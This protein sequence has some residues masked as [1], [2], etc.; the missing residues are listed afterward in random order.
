MQD[1]AKSRTGMHALNRFFV[2][3]HGM[4][5]KFLTTLV[6]KYPHILSKSEAE[7]DSTLLAFE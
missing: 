4:T 3:K 7:L 6:V 5:D 2:E 1:S